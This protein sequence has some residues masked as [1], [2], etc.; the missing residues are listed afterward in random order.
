MDDYVVGALILYLDI[1][2]IF[3]YLLQLFSRKWFSN[4]RIKIKNYLNKKNWKPTNFHG[5]YKYL[6]MNV[7]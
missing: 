4:I 3:L 6:W 5:F 1:I 7:Y 2:Q